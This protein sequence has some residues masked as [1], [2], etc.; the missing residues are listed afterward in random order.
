MADW[1]EAYST[2]L[3]S[4]LGQYKEA[5]GNSEL[6]NE[7]LAEVKLE[8]LQQAA[9]GSVA[10]PNNLRVAIR[11]VFL[12]ELDPEDQDDEE[13]IIQH[14]LSVSEKRKEDA[15]EGEHVREERPRPTKAG[16]YRKPFTAFTC[17]QR[18]FKDDLNL[19]DRERRDTKDPKTIGQRTKIVQKWWES[20]SDDRKA[21]AGRAAEKWN[22]LGAPKETHDLYVPISFMAREFIDTVQRTMGCHI[23][24]FAT[25]EAGENQIKMTVFET[26]PADG[27][28]AFTKS[29][30]SSKDWVLNGE[31]ILTDYLLTAPVEEEDL[32]E[33]QE[34]EI[35]VDEDGNPQ[36]PS[37]S[38]Q[39]LKVQQ[40]L[41]RAVFQ[42]AYAKFTE[43]PKAKV[44]W[45]LL[46]KSPLEYLDK[47]SIPDGFTMKDPSKWTKADLQLLWTHWHSLEGE[48][49]V[50][51]SFIN[52]RKED[53]PLALWS[54]RKGKASS[55]KKVYMSPGD[56]SE[57]SRGEVAPGRAEDDTPQETNPAWHAS[58][59]RVKF[60]KS[61]SIMPWYQELVE[62]VLALPKTAPGMGTKLDMPVWATW[63]WSDQYLPADIHMDGS[64]IW[65][66][67]GKLQSAR[68]GCSLKGLQ[69]VL[70]FGLLLRECKW[71]QE[72][73]PDDPE[74]ADLDFLLNSELGVE[75][76]ED[77]MDAV[78]VVVTR[79]QQN[80]SH[81]GEQERGEG[82][83]GKGGCRVG[84]EMSENEGGSE[85]EETPVPRPMKKRKREGS[86]N[87]K[88]KQK[89]TKA[90]HH[91]DV[92]Q[93]KREKRERKQ[94]KR[95]LGLGL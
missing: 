27:K 55:K 3:S 53:A 87:L 21:E 65:K 29:S 33:K 46:I 40:N 69:V 38:G 36:V 47:E 17:G 89:V 54:D 58:K 15:G 26:P 93:G 76:G 41:A 75:R 86:V 82:I 85:E 37:W 59:D 88:Q 9:P 23:V 74:V 78:G 61:L 28:K 92:V 45:G 84:E 10:L 68:F 80:S 6:Q 31:H 52:C 16:D 60:L 4:Y 25:H 64:S 79:L 32:K 71:A 5:R 12:P 50:I 19:Y 94:T 81:M 66:A 83:G 11:R 77:V 67:L 62:L 95:A 90:G 34:V 39:K 48:D 24:M 91:E 20:L 51:V 44:P 22:K 1:S 57:A 49:K 8:I 2:I 56:D 30:E 70:G 35:T 42:A 13:N 7:I 18:L 73:E 14:I 72:V 63:A 43:R